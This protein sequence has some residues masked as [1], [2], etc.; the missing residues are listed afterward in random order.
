M[1]CASDQMDASVRWIFAI[2]AVVGSQTARLH[3][4][5]W[6]CHANHGTLAKRVRMNDRG[7]GD[8]GNHA[9]SHRHE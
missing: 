2:T 4:A 1:R 6:A 9:V 8:D 3:E 7:R 5:A